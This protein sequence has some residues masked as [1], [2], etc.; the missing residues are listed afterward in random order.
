MT[1]IPLGAHLVTPR[2]GYTHHGIYVGDG[3]VVHY[4][5]LANGLQ[6]GPTGETDISS[7]CAGR[8]LKFK[9]YTNS[10]DPS[11][12]VRRA[13]SR[14]SEANYGVFNNNCEHFCLWCCLGDHR[15]P[16]VDTAAFV[17]TPALG[18]IIGTNSRILIAAGGVVS[19]LSGAGVMSGLAAVGSIVGGGVVA[20]I[21]VLGGAPATLAAVAL[22]HTA[23]ADNDALED[24]E[25]QSRTAGRRASFAGA[26]AGIA[27]SILTVSVAGSTAGLSAA[28]IT[29]GLAA[30]GSAF[31]GG[32]A[33]GAFIVTAAPSI[34]ALSVG[35]GVYKLA[36][37]LK[38]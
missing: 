2:R 33:A 30:I 36:R 15:S 7:F 8:G 10:F 35:Y 3:M 37:W 9:T 18:G 22:N 24:C 21:A 27:G 32:M 20:G 19:G 34:A 26:A 6:S 38:T 31:G 5:G 25:R 13:R 29:S 17:G 14:L 11:E 12:I 28:G 1:A 4:V 16:Q 23:L